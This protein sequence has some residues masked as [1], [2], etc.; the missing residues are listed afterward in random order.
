MYLLT[1]L[2]I[3]LAKRQAKT[4]E[5]KTKQHPISQI[6]QAVIMSEDG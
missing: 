3:I 1:T 5:K 6:P 2:I 4:K